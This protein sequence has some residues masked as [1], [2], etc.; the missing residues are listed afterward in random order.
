MSYLND[1]D[2]LEAE[3]G[4]EEAAYGDRR[5]EEERHDYDGSGD[6]MLVREGPVVTAPVTEQTPAR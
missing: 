3:Q 1:N 6:P 5:V 4:E 2:G